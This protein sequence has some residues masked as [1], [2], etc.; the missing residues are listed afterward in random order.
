MIT[1]AKVMDYGYF[2]RLYRL[3]AALLTF[4]NIIKNRH[5]L[6]N[7]GLWWWIIKPVLGYFHGKY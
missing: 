7:G 6:A 2:T 5:G 4:I 1:T 3:A